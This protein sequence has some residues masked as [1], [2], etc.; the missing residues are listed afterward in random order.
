M[1]SLAGE[2]QLDAHRFE[3]RLVTGCRREAFES[4]RKPGESGAVEDNTPGEKKPEET[5]AAG[6]KK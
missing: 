6:G 4:P 3:V 2:H 5:K 1:Q